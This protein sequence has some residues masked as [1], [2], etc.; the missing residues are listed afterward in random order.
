MLAAKAGAATPRGAPDCSWAQSSAERQNPGVL[1]ST[2]LAQMTVAEKLGL[3]NLAAAGG[4]ENRNTGVPR[5]CIPALTLQDGPNG[6]AYRARRVTQ[7]PASLG[8]AATFDT[9]LA[10]RYGQVQGAEASR[11]GIDVVQGPELNLDRV[12]ESG[13]AFEAFGEDPTLTA[14]MG[15]ADINGIQSQRVMAE[16]KHY[17]AYNQETARL[18]V[19]QRISPRALAELY[20][21][22]FRAAVESADVAAIMCAYGSLNGVNDCSSPPLY[23][24][25]TAWGFVGVVRSDLGAVTAP[26]QAFAAGMSMIK[27]AQTEALGLALQDGQLPEA[28]L[29]DAAWRVLAEMFAFNMVEQ[30]PRGGIDAAATN[31]LDASIARQV[32]DSSIVLLKNAHAILPLSRTSAPSVAVIGADASSATMSAGYG[33]ARVVAPYVVT[34]LAGLRFALRG[35]AA[36]SYTPGGGAQ[37]LLP[38]IPGTVLHT[39]A[40]LNGNK[41][42]PEF[43]GKDPEGV[44]DLLGQLAQP[45]SASVATAAVAGNGNGWSSWSGT[46]VPPRTGLYTFSITEQ[47][48]TWFSIGRTVLVASPGLHSPAPWSAAVELVAGHRYRLGVRWYQSTLDGEPRLGWMFDSPSIAE[49][50]RA[51]RAARVA[52]VFANDFSSE[53]VDRPGLSLPGD[54]DAL[55]S[56]VAA[57]N[58]HTVVVLNTGGPVLMPWLHQVA[59]VLEAWYPGQEG[60]NAVA[61][62]LTGK[63]DPSGHLPVTFPASDAAVPARTP[64]AWPGSGATVSYREGLDIGYRFDQA[65]HLVPLFPFG[66]G[67]SY[68]TFSLSALSVTHVPGGVVARVAVRNTGPVSGKAV[69]QAYLAYPPG[70]GE[71]PEQLRAFAVV[72]LGPGQSATAK[73]TVPGSAFGVYQ[74]GAFRNLPGT[75]RLSVG[76]SSS[77][78][79]LFVATGAP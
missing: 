13:R 32:A 60:G 48:D 40:P 14:A 59:A 79:G 76:Q 18:L 61:D 68:T 41:V 4:Y 43:T 28:R 15:V 33:S 57:A 11:K 55:I 19:N 63:V 6:I 72:P 17:T 16:A 36:V 75:Y 78:L 7:L 66:F 35:R 26:V 37:L 62:V 50:V 73:L 1:A 39:A 27:P 58:P 24:S 71:P 64:A 9:G 77:D 30:P 47:G 56:A 49:A 12:P 25:L 22:P 29:D 34:P 67:L 65:F 70:S 8:L 5:L 51:A 23:R 74:R 53:G 54:E 21:P 10:Y 52:V 20:Q 31:P 69:V 46:L 44:S 2:V 38:A 45:L 3:V 42:P